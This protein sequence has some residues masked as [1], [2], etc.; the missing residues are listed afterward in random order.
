MQRYNSIESIG[1]ITSSCRGGEKKSPPT[2][3]IVQ[4]E[5]DNKMVLLPV[6]HLVNG[7][8]TGIKINNTAT[9]KEDINS[10]K[11]QRG[12]IIQLGT[13]EVCVEQLQ[14]FEMAANVDHENITDCDID[15]ADDNEQYNN[16]KQSFKKKQTTSLVSSS[17]VSKGSKSSL[18]NNSMKQARTIV[19]NKDDIKSKFL[20]IDEEK[21]EASGNED[22]AFINKCNDSSS[23][24]K[25][26]TK[27]ICKSTTNKCKTTTKRVPTDKSIIERQGK[28]Q[29]ACKSQIVINP[30]VE[31]TNN[32][33]NDAALINF[34]SSGQEARFLDSGNRDM[35]NRYD[36]LSKR[37][38]ELSQENAALRS[39]IDRLTKEN[40]DIR[41]STMPI[42]DASG[43]Q[44]FINMGKYFS[45]KAPNADI[46]QYATALKIT[47][48]RDL[49]A[50][51]EDTTSNTTRQ[52]VKLLYSS[53]QLIEMVGPEVPEETRSVIREFAEAQK[54][55]ISDLKFN[56]A[57]NGVFRSKKSEMRKKEP[58]NKSITK[59][60]N[61]DV[62]KSTNRRDKGQLT[63]EQMM[64]K[65]QHS[66]SNHLNFDEENHD[67]EENNDG[68]ESTEENE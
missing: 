53:E 29:H 62:D 3:V 49:I 48:P 39:H 38:N 9:F 22:E 37:C 65:T 50:C 67:V 20:Q 17:C 8:V 6:T 46:K 54:G 28:S 14:V 12:K 59:D 21:D 32:L 26:S 10:R 18:S 24:N 11:Q 64:S 47:D 19:K 16:R 51:I 31:N 43:R 30:R 44:W 15:E 55:P 34:P 63:L 27:S 56:E 40:S 25:S 52:V 66:K 1:S 35:V 13:K 57:I 61:N 58:E 60:N 41:R 7:S 45:N 36:Y 4:R 2:H 5:G 42:P 68:E 33:Q 23:S